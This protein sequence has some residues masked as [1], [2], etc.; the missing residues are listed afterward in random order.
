MKQSPTATKETAASVGQA[1]A[2]APAPA[3]DVTDRNL[4]TPASPIKRR[5]RKRTGY[6]FQRNFKLNAE[7]IVA[8]DE[9]ADLADITL[10]QVVERGVAAIRKLRE[11]K[12]DDY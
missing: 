6:S 8:L 11:L 3:A 1:P 10:G 9:E 12:I 4:E 5:N 7:T 2:P